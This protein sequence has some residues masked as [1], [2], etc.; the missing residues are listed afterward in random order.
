MRSFFG[1]D[2]LSF[3]DPRGFVALIGLVLGFGHTDHL[4]LGGLGTRAPVAD[5]SWISIS[6]LG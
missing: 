4:G 1:K 5:K 3:N 2:T 6:G